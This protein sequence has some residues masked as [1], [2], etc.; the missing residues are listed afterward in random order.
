LKKR[1][2][3]LCPQA[4]G[5]AAASWFRE[6]IDLE[7]L[8]KLLGKK[9]VPVHRHSWIYLLGGAAMFLF[10]MQLISGCL[11]M[12]YYQPSEATA[13]ESVVKIMQQVPF[14]WLIRSLH[15]WGAQLFIAI[16]LVHFITVLFSRA[17]RKPRELTWLSGMLLLF[18][19][20]AFGFSG[21][22][23][24]W[25]ELAY[26]ATRVG[27]EIPRV[28]PG[29]GGFLVHLLRGGEEVTGDTIT[30]F[31]AAH[32]VI[33]PLVFGAMLLVHLVLIQ[34]QGMSIPLGMAPEAVKDHRPFFGEFLLLD[35][36]LWLV[37][38]GA[39]VTLAVVLPAE[40][41]V[42]ADPLK[43]PP[44]G[45]RPEW[46]FLFLFKTLKM[47]P[48]TLGVGL[49]AFGALFL[50]AL[51]FLDRRAMRGQ[52]SPGFTALFIALLSYVVV[53]EVWALLAP[54]A[55]GP[56]ETLSAPTYN[57]AHDL[58]SLILFWSAIGF[59]IF[60][61][62]RLWEENT[63]IRMLYQGGGSQWRD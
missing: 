43:P 59:V 45:I 40:V 24:P 5:A 61:L 7:P 39:I 10:V 27:T 15:A 48:E 8:V 21:Y 17:Y 53:F 26:Y 31:F 11:L 1:L 12:L 30:R 28:V 25:N 32:V 16:A 49:F 20:L 58:V 33:L 60:H 14:G 37:V 55:K 13:H 36:G 38:L 63:R 22:L 23:L 6:R 57:L 19:A 9:T 50:M 4:V 52:R 35:A 56:P 51:P 41:G 2:E 29:I 44:E 46:Y 34:V 3:N 18:L 42:K 62:R 54:V 47:V